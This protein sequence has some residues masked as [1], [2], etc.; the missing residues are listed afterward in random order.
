METCGFEWTHDRMAH[1]HHICRRIA[2]H[3][4]LAH[5]CDCGDQFEKRH[6]D[7]EDRAVRSDGGW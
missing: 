7:D 6:D 4:G 1:L 2:G 3:G 5:E